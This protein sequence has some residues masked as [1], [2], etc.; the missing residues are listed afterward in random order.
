MNKAHILSFL[1]VLWSFSASYGKNHNI[2]ISTYI[3]EKTGRL[4]E[5]IDVD[6]IKTDTF[7]ISNDSVDISCKMLEWKEINYKH[8]NLKTGD[9]VE[10]TGNTR[11]GFTKEEKNKNSRLVIQKKYYPDNGRISFYGRYYNN[12]F[13]NRVSPN[14]WIEYYDRLDE[15]CD[16]IEIPNN[17]YTISI[18]VDD[19]LSY[20]N[21]I[22]SK[23]D[24]GYLCLDSVIIERPF[25]EMGIPYWSISTT[26]LLSRN[27]SSWLC[28]TGS[29]YLHL[30]IN[31]FNGRVDFSEDESKYPSDCIQNIFGDYVHPSINLNTTPQAR[32]VLAKEKFNIKKFHTDTINN[33]SVRNTCMI[34]LYKD[35]L[36]NRKNKVTGQVIN[37]EG[38]SKSGFRKSDGKYV[39][40]LF[41]TLGNVYRTRKV[42]TL[43]ITMFASEYDSKGNITDEKDFSDCFGF[44][45][46]NYINTKLESDIKKWVTIPLTDDEIKFMKVGLIN[47]MENYKKYRYLIDTVKYKMPTMMSDKE[48]NLKYS[49]RVHDTNIQAI[50]KN[51]K[52]NRFVDYNFLTEKLEN[53]RGVYYDLNASFDN[54]G[55]NQD[56]D[57]F[58][59]R[60]VGDNG[61]VLD[62]SFKTS[63]GN[64]RWIYWRYN[65]EE[66]QIWHIRVEY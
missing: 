54:H 42:D 57:D 22:V 40:A 29:F 16:Y 34:R 50:M 12:A 39:V 1:F 24:N 55:L 43:G 51:L 21:N 31:P 66:A 28:D 60:I 27:K 19:I 56:T 37:I 15:K 48:I 62:Y 33:D 8:E 4:M 35:F 18:S 17:R 44:D 14:C 32:I 23:K 64:G 7:T 5:R 38:N 9:I 25:D 20:I 30:F 65:W 10:I 47:S 46:E 52:V 49:L 26:E 3:H 53:A 6:K 36:Y 2:P 61:V 58:K 13:K 63:Y 41:D 45:I 59:S 11:Y